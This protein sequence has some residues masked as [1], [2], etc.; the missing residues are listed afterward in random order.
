MWRS[1]CRQ[2]NYLQSPPLGL[3]LAYPFKDVKKYVKTCDICQRMGR[4]VQSNEMPLQPE[5]LIEPFKRWALDFVGLITP[6]SR[7]K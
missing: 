5:V 6:M 4:P 1:I 7:K 2:K 3:L